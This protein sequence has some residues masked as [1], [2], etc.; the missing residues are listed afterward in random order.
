MRSEDSDIHYYSPTAEEHKRY[1][2][3]YDRLIS[4]MTTR[5]EAS[6]QPM[7][8][9]NKQKLENWAEIRTEQLVIEIQETAA[10]MRAL[11]EQAAAAKD[12]LEKVDIRKEA[13]KKK[14]SLEKLEQSFHARATAIQEEAA[15]DIAAFNA[16]M[17]ISPI[18]VINTVLKF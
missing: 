13:D 16:G 15:R 9:Y 4:E 6:I 1:A 14:K 11:D 8:E 10:E 12:F 2:Q 17:K 5:Y 7:L 18:L 3:I